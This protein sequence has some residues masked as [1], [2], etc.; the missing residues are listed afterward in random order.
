V[1]EFDD[2]S[3]T[4]RITRFRWQLESDKAEAFRSTNPPRSPQAALAEAIREKY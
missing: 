3:R 1:K 2:P 4:H